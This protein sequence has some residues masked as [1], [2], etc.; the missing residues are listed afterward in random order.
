M[1]NLWSYRHS[2]NPFYFSQ[3]LCYDWNKDHSKEQKLE[4]LEIIFVLKRTLPDYKVPNPTNV[5]IWKHYCFN[6]KL[7]RSPLDKE[8]A[9]VEEFE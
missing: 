1:M 5:S 9:A 3:Y 7:S 6:K 8:V 2:K 4:E